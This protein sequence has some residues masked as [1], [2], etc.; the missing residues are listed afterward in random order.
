M[1]FYSN[2]YG[3][4]AD[5]VY[6]HVHV[7]VLTMAMVLS[8]GYF[9]GCGYCGDYVHVYGCGQS[10]AMVVAASVT[11]AMSTAIFMDDTWLWQWLHQSY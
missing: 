10:T 7:Y 1:C 4:D 11:I 8:S 3:Y 5:Y 9:C 6:V 2:G